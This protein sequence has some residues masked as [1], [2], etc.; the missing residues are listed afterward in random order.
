MIAKD[1]IQH[2]L[3]VVDWLYKNCFI[4]SVVTEVQYNMISITGEKK[5]KH[6]IDKF[7]YCYN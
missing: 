3:F 6:L 1:Q 5:K 4:D 2:P 7:E